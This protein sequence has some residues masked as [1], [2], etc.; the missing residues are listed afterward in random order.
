M[1]RKAILVSFIFL[2][3]FCV[4]APV[5]STFFSFNKM[6]HKYLTLKRQVRRELGRA[7]CQAAFVIQDLQYSRLK[8]SSREHERFPA[9]SLIKVPILAVAF[10]A[11]SE[12]KIKLSQSVVI[13]RGDITGGSGILKSKKPPITLTFEELLEIMIAHSD[14]TATNKVITILGYKYIN[15][16]FRAL[17]L[18]HTTIER[19]MMDFSRRK[20]GV[21]NYTCAA[22]IVLL[23]K[24]IYD[25]KFIN[26]DFSVLALEFLK[27][28]KVNDR[29]PLYLPG[30]LDIAHKTGL[31]RGVVHDAGIV[32][33][34]NGDYL[35]CVMTRR[36]RD[37]TYAKKFIAKLALLTYNLYR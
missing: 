35:I 15:R 9:A 34:S 1:K 13:E 24:R 5:Y 28:Q 29:I 22:D 20:N 23:F 21:E 37:S 6:Q 17:G 27:K 32:F 31:E 8:I 7:R 18:G 36:V 10:K 19:K 12:N 25:K 14:N 33:T 30:S 11:V 26:T 2:L 3:A 4:I 16:S